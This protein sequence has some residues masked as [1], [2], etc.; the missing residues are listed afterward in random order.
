MERLCAPRA[1]GHVRPAVR[2]A[3]IPVCHCEAP[4]QLKAGTPEL[5]VDASMQ[6]WG[7]IMVG[8]EARGYFTPEEHTMMI[9]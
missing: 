9:A 2:W 3:R 7:A 4:L 8:Q 6:G 5:Y 1:T